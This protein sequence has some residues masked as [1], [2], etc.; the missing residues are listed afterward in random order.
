MIGAAERDERR[1]D[2]HEQEVLDHVDR[3][4]R[5]VV[6]LDP[7]QEGDRDRGEPGEER[8]GP[9]PRHRVRRM[10]R[11]DPADGRRASRRRR[12]RGAARP[13]ARTTSRGAGRRSM[14]D[15]AGRDRGRGPGRERQRESAPPTNAASAAGQGSPERSDTPRI[16]AC[17]RRSRVAPALGA[18]GIMNGQSGTSPAV[19]AW[20][21]PTSNFGIRAG[22]IRR[23]V[24]DRSC[25]PAPG[26]GRRPE[27][28]SPDSSPWPSSSAPRLAG[29]ERAPPWSGASFRPIRPH[30]RA[31]DLRPLHIV[32]VIAAAIFFVVEGLIVWSVIRYRRR[33]G[34]NELPPQTHGNNLAEIVWT[35]IPTVIVVFLFF[36]SWQTLNRVEA[37]H[38]NRT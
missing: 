16:V 7:G 9:A 6:A 11:V 20:P 4:E 26:R 19:A 33:P 23:G 32:F 34:D 10:R 3:E 14:A 30:G 18:A 2:E 8:D 13:A 12:S 24:E 1:G 31:R 38:R 22:A 37:R 29:P 36:I 17:S 15:P 28:S 27:R 25:R 21:T 5:R 35:V